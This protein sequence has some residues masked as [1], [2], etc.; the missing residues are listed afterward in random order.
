[1]FDIL[2]KLGFNWEANVPFFIR[3]ISRII[4]NIIWSDHDQDLCSRSIWKDWHLWQR[5][6]GRK[7]CETSYFYY[8]TKN[9]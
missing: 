5:V 9:Q 7:H 8:H 2:E 1:M 6:F 4:H 3:N